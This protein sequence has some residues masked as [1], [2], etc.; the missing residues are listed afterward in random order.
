[1]NS[2][3]SS[4]TTVTG[5]T[6]WSCSP[7]GRIAFRLRLH[8][9]VVMPN[10][11]HLLAEPTMGRAGGPGPVGQAR[12]HGAIDQAGP[13]YPGQALCPEEASEPADIQAGCRCG[14][15]DQRR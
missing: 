10:H 11:Y 9:C 14:G 2:A 12:F 6:S 3:S 4:A 13:W 15:K 5:S 1:M 7:N 8:A